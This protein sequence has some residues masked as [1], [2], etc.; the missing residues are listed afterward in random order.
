[1]KWVVIEDN[2][3]PDEYIAIMVTD[4]NRKL[5]LQGKTSSTFSNADDA[6]NRARALR[7]AFGVRMIRI[8][9]FESYSSPA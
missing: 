3:K 8:F 5:Q 7:D 1:M 6:M 2:P 9:H 4:E